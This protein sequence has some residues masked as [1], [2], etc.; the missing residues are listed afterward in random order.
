MSTKE[1]KRSIE[2]RKLISTVKDQKLPFLQAVELLRTLK[3]TKFQETLDLVIS[4]K[5][6]VKSKI[7]SKNVE[8]LK[9]SVVLPSGSGKTYKVAAIVTTQ[10]EAEQALAA[11]AFCAGGESLI[12]QISEQGDSLNF[13]Y[14]VTTP[15]AMTLVARIARILSPKNLMPSLKNGT[16]SADIITLVKNFKSGNTISYRSERLGG[17]L[18]FRVGPMIFSDQELHDNFRAVIK[19]ILGEKDI[20]SIKSVHIKTTMSPSLVVQVV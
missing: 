10:A 3:T 5:R 20:H 1:S 16:V 9:G 4:F 18:H 2:N 19:H 11:G 12:K 14:C 13:D 8:V 7:K 17:S 6:N 15:S